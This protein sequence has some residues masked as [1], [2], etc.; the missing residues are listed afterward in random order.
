LPVIARMMETA[1]GRGVTLVV[2]KNAPRI[3]VLGKLIPI[4]FA[5]ELRFQEAERALARKP[6]DKLRR[7]KK[8]NDKRY[9]ITLEKLHEI[10]EKECGEGR[11]VYETAQT[12]VNS[13]CSL[14]G[15]SD[16][17]QAAIEGAKAGEQDW[18][19]SAGG[20]V[21]NRIMEAARNAVLPQNAPRKRLTYRYSKRAL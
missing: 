18:N 1:P 9:V 4:G 3:P 2:T 19:I 13:L 6:K 14:V 11:I 20:L 5:E 8:F 16:I 17:F 10:L 21:A 7:R 15:P 12:A